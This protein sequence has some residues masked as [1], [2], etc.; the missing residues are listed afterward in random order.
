MSGMAGTPGFGQRYLA[1]R[2]AEPA[3]QALDRACSGQ[4]VVAASSEKVHRMHVRRREAWLCMCCRRVKARCVHG[5]TCGSI[6]LLHTNAWRIYRPQVLKQARRF[7]VILFLEHVS[8][9]HVLSR[10]SRCLSGGDF[11]Q[12][13]SNVHRMGRAMWHG[14]SLR[15]PPWCL[16]PIPRRMMH[17]PARGRYDRGRTMACVRSKWGPWIRWRWQSRNPAAK[18]FPCVV[19]I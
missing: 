14:S 7:S 19:I 5:N 18:Q 3:S 17:S 15:G 9:R 16:K 10:D 8:A 12:V 1:G 13:P 6:I 2:A 11:G 4:G